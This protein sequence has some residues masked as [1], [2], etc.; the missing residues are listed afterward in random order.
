M[1]TPGDFLNPGA[2]SDHIHSLAGPLRSWSSTSSSSYRVPTSYWSRLIE[3]SILVP[4]LVLLASIFLSANILDVVVASITAVLPASVRQSFW[5]ASIKVLP[6]SLIF[7][8]DDWLAPF[9]L[10]RQPFDRLGPAAAHE[11]KSS[12]LARIL[13]V[14]PGGRRYNPNS[15]TGGGSSSSGGGAG[16]LF[17]SVTHAGKTGLSR[18]MPKGD[19]DRPAGLGNLSNSCY[20]NSV[21]QA[22]SALEPLRQYLSKIADEETA[23]HLTQVETSRTLDD[24]VHI[25]STPTRNGETLWTPPILKRMSTFQQQ[26]AQEYFC[27]LLSEIEEE[28]AKALKAVQSKPDLASNLSL[29]MGLEP[30]AVLPLSPP[31]KDKTYS[32]SSS[33]SRSGSDSD[34]SDD[35]GYHSPATPASSLASSLAS[36]FRIP[37]EGLLAQRIVCQSCGY[38]S[39]LSMSP[40]YSLTVNPDVGS[41]EYRLEETLDNFSAVENIE[42]VQCASCT[43]IK[44]RRLIKILIARAEENDAK[45]DKD[46]AS[47]PKPRANLTLPL[48]RL[49]AVEAALDDDDFEEKTLS[50][51]CKIPEKQRVQSTKSRQVGIARAPQSIAFHVNRSRFDERTGYT[52]KNPAAIR[53]PLHLDLGPW[54]LG[55]AA[56]FSPPILPVGDENE[57]AQN[58]SARG[59]DDAEQWQLPAQ[60]PMVAGSQHDPRL[61]GPFYELRAVITH[62]GQHENGHYVCYRKHPTVKEETPVVAPEEVTVI[63]VDADKDTSDANTPGDRILADDEETLRAP[64]EVPTDDDRTIVDDS[65]M[66]GGDNDNTATEAAG[67]QQEEKGDDGQ[68][69]RLSDQN[70]SL[71]DEATVLSQGGVF[72]LFYDRIDARS[73]FQHPTEKKDIQALYDMALGKKDTLYSLSPEPVDVK[74]ST[75]DDQSKS[76][77]DASVHESPSL[78][79]VPT[80]GPSTFSQPTDEAPAT[81]RNGPDQVIDYV[82]PVM[83]AEA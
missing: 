5:G 31:R 40:F 72:M 63:N 48:E 76:T 78:C 29:S 10:P 71:S 59:M 8:I 26:D 83:A 75:I 3:P 32:S 56:A 80:S 13:G 19:T 15:S 82:T 18:L 34:C 77:M 39:G 45:A 79:S 14:G 70:V 17:A 65:S 61:Q 67:L 16:G 74:D 43:L 27:K 46:G 36:S 23:G 54:C 60:L 7:A 73:T 49:A 66:A 2:P 9:P 22:L 30:P 68:W 55:S 6:A 64:S 57:P 28:V 41:A 51:K 42:G 11:A 4:F 69:W 47:E 35:S 24:L 1:S 12:A 58:L 81:P 25:L 33:P 37:L 20:Q 38:S 62:Y 53:F 21:L 52:F 44:V 50:E